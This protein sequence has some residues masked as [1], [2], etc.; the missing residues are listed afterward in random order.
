MT[1]HLH[2]AQL[3]SVWFW[4]ALKK[5]DWLWLVVA[6][7]IASATVSLI[8]QLSDSMT[9]SMERKA[10]MSLQADLVLQSSQPIDAK[11]LEEA[12]AQGLKTR[13]SLSLVTMALANEQ[14]QL[15]KLNA[16]SDP[17]PLRGE[18][19]TRTTDTFEFA[20]LDPQSV[21]IEPKLIDLMQLTPESQILLGEREFKIAGVIAASALINPAAQ[22]APQITLALSQIDSTQLI[23]AGSRISYQL[24]FAGDSASITAFAKQLKAQ[25]IPQWQITSANQASNDLGQALERAQ[26]FLDLSALVTVLIAGMSILI[27]SRFYLQRWQNTLVMLRS[28]GASDQQLGQIFRWQLMWLALFASTLGASLGVLIAYLLTPILSDFF[29][30]WVSVSPVWAWSMGVVSGTLVLWSFT[31]QVLHQVLAHS[32]FSLLKQAPNQ[33]R[34]LPILVSFGLLL[35][36]ML[37][38]I[39]SEFIGWMLLALIIFVALLVLSA[40]LILWLMTRTNRLAT[41][42]LR[43]SLSNLLRQPNLLRIQIISLG[44]VLFALVLMSFLRQDLLQDWKQSLPAQAPNHFVINIQPDQ[45]DYTLTQIESITHNIDAFTRYPMVR[46]RLTQLNGK[47]LNVEDLSSPRAKRLLS[48]EANNAIS[49]QLPSHNKILAQLP[50]QPV[51]RVSVESD[52]A[53]LFGIKL[54][55]ELTFNFAGREQTYTV[56]SLREVKWQ[57]FELNFFFILAGEQTQSLPFSYIGNFY[58]PKEISSN[59][60][61]QNLAQNAS[62]V[63]LLDVRQ[64][65]SQVEEIMQQASQAISWLFVLTL[66]ASLAVLFSATLASQQ[67]RIQ[68]WMLLRTLGA[69]SR[70]IYLIGL[71]EFVL[72][73]LAAGIMAA[74]YA[75]ITSYLLS[76]YLLDLPASLDWQLWAA[77]LLSGALIVLLIGVL[78]QRHYLKFSA[79]QLRKHSE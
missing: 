2:A 18:L 40:Q 52:I 64:I 25:N 69:S 27:A 75:Q 57:S 47:T 61:S 5:G 30:P 32:P 37:L 21:W 62:G 45:L 19:Q 15:V 10:A 4:R 59:Q 48:R 34:L 46:G 70:Q 73:G 74:S 35:S 6:V 55:D 36:L 68:S 28:T 56:S 54:G 1:N 53:E 66:V 22:F 3:A 9:L 63:I 60:L 26:L 24:E 67:S 44:V 20:P 39:D 58:L 65:I 71:T 12:Q 17:T 51:N 79:L 38:L 50:E 41:G 13:Q 11:W 31:W 16:V 14:F 78:T 33:Q 23:G 7:T 43:I 77:S 49:E 29:D 42:W 76:T 72:L 8:T